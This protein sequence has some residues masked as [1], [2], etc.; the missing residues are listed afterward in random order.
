MKTPFILALLLL[1]DGAS[2]IFSSEPAHHCTIGYAMGNAVPDGRAVIWRNYDWDSPSQRTE[3]LYQ[4]AHDWLNAWGPFKWVAPSEA[5]GLIFGGL[6][7]KGLGCFNT[8]ISDFYSEGDYLAGNYG[9]Q[10]WILSNC[11]TVVQVRQAVIEQVNFNN[12]IT[13]GIDHGWNYQD[14]SPALSLVVI[15]AQ[16]NT[17]MFE[18]AKTF[19]Y[20]YD[21]ANPNRLAQFPVQAGARAN[22]PHRLTDHHDNTGTNYQ[23]TGGRR[24]YEARDRLIAV[25]QNGNKLTV[26][27][28]M[29]S[30]ARWGN[31]GHDGSWNQYRNS[32][33]NTMDASI[34]W[35]AAPGEDP[36]TAVLFVAMGNPN[37]SP[38]VPVWVVNGYRLSQRLTSQ[39]ETGIAQQAVKLYSKMSDAGDDKYINTFFTGIEANFREAVEILRE[40]W[41]LDCFS[42]DEADAVSD[43]A[44][45]TAYYTMASLNAGTGMILNPTPVLTEITAMADGRTVTFSRVASDDGS[46]AST[47]WDFG[48]GTVSNDISPSHTYAAE[49][50]YLVRCRIEDDH[51][52]RNSKWKLVT[53][54]ES[55][56]SRKKKMQLSQTD[57]VLCRSGQTLHVKIP[58]SLSVRGT[59]VQLQDARGRIQTRIK[60]TE[61]IFSLDLTYLAS[62]V[63]FIRIN[64][65]RPIMKKFVQIR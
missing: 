50:C 24:Y 32:N 48:D 34:I 45:E 40:H 64:T 18:L 16:G 28:V 36:R 59:D 11:S 44:A 25:A 5:Q 46:I 58:R 19:Y 3:L 55:N 47:G 49:G 60:A 38:F 35:G 37:Y 42:E 29:D 27:E 41:A 51:G 31:P 1:M 2:S 26:Q 61:N 22:E 4:G 9:A 13:G 65:A 21:P 20:E 57:I 63:Y 43:E 33:Y 53:I 23:K 15:D 6:N 52:S 8:L 30:I 14:Y 54:S 62:G 10:V 17:T 12:G 7:E 39:T 56:N